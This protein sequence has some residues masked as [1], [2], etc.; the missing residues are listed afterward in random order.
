MSITLFFGDFEKGV[1]KKQYQF[2]LLIVGLGIFV[3]TLLLPYLSGEKILLTTD[4]AISGTNISS[5]DLFPMLAYHWIAKPLLGA[6]G[7]MFCKVPAVLMLF[8]HGSD[9]NNWIFPMGCLGASIAFMFLFRRKVVNVAPIAL[10]LLVAFWMGNNFTMI[11]AG[12]ML[13]PFVVLFFVCSLLPAGRAGKGSVPAALVWGSC[14]GLMF[15][16]Q[17]DVAMFFAIFSGMFFVFN[18]WKNQGLKLLIWLKVMFPAALVAFLFAAGPLLNGYNQHVKGAAQIQ[19]EDAGAKWDYITQ[20]SWPPEDCVNFIAPGFTGWRSGEPEGPYWGRCG[21]SSGWEQTGQG[22]RNFKLDAYYYGM[23]ALG[24]AVFSLFS[25]RR[26][27]HRSE[28]LF[29]GGAALVSLL[30]AL[31]KF[32]PLYALFFKLPIVSNIRSP[33]KFLQ[34]FQI[35]IA[36]L[37]AYGMNAML[38]GKRAFIADEGASG[39]E[40][41]KAE[42]TCRRFFW[43]LVVLLGILCLS[44][45]SQVLGEGEDVASYVAE[46]WKR[47]VAETIVSNKTRALLHASFMTAS[48]AAAFAVFGF[49]KLE[50]VRR[51]GSWIA[52][53]LVLIVAVDAVKLSKHY[54][55]EMPRSYIKANA[56]TD[57]LKAD[58][59][60]QRVA[61]IS[62]QGINNIWITYLMPYN[63]IPTFNFTDMPR[64]ATEYKALLTAGQKDTLNM[65]RFSAVKYVMAPS[66]A[67]QQLAAANCKKVFSYGLADAGHGEF[68]VVPHANGQLAVYELLGALPR[69]ALFAGAKKGTDE[70]AL[71]GMADFSM[72]VLPEDSPLPELDGAGQAGSVDIL[73]YR[74]GKVKL[75]VRTQVPAILRCADRFDAA[76][77]ATIDGKKADVERVDFLCQ[78]VYIPE[79]EHEVVMRYAPSRHFFHMQCIGYLI[80]LGSLIVAS[81]QKKDPHAED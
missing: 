80:L 55:K 33:I 26:S 65:W 27:K 35:C 15:I 61:F 38:A 12:H 70:Q 43:I 45:F 56:L 66:G 59:G 14:V 76:W 10:G 41:G 36:V 37:A 40:S 75:R 73:S 25:L 9:W 60:R 3:G 16:Q 18:L 2:I 22:F 68:N 57:F 74:D 77:K 5:S 11:Y 52:V 23:I 46:G 53:A 67:E 7:A 4:A 51:F 72:V 78:G 63:R 1:M 49:R 62:Q 81:R 21:Q 29:W 6:S 8:I 69:Y 50:K 54:V 30:L 79:G 17:P 19:S 32:F 58:I 48:L 31:G 47:G 28:I 13:K 20:W 71:S 39:N 44:A 64:M 34:V 42:E 24:F